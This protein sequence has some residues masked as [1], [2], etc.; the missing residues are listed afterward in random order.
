[1]ELRN[2]MRKMDLNKKNEETQAS[3]I[4]IFYAI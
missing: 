3:L 2:E 1:M 4:E